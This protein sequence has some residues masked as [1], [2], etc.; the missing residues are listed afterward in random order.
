MCLRPQHIFFSLRNGEWQRGLNNPQL[1][2]C[3]KFFKNSWV[4]C[5]ISD[6]EASFQTSS[7]RKCHNLSIFKYRNT[8]ICPYHPE[9]NDFQK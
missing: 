2:F 5:K 6:L 4:S 8:R 7:N 9:F 3:S 1:N